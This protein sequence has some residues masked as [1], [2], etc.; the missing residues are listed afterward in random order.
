VVHG[1][2]PVTGSALVRHPGVGYVTF[3]GSTA[4]GARIM[5]DAAG[6]GIK[7]V[8]L[9]L[10]GKS[11]TLVHA[12]CGDLDVVADHVTW[13][14]TRNAGQLC[15]AGSRLVVDERIADDL[16]ERVTQRMQALQPGPTWAAASTLSPIISE[17]QWQRIDALVRRTVDEGARVR[18]GAAPQ[19]I[20]GGCFYPGTVLDHVD[21]SMT[22]YR[23]EIFGPVLC[24]QRFRDPAQALALANHPVYGL[25]ASVF[26]RDVS[27]ALASARGLKAGTVW[28]NRWGRTPEMMSSP[29]GG[30]GQ[31][32][33][34]KESGRAGIDNFLRSKS[35]WIDFAATPELSQ[36]GRR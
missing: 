1:T 36:G 32:G 12:D 30:Y 26:T 21:E 14:I 19:K 28:V 5:A 8:A 20:G 11:A 23:E 15:Y 18:C 33:F 22:G 10:G 9:E 6:A 13:G 16:V 35:V 4:T 29:F 17:R 7:P 2:G 3:T 27:R 24:V 31:S 25:S 34:G